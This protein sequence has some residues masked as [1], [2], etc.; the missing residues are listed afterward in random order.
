MNKLRYT[1]VMYF[2]QTHQVIGRAKMHVLSHYIDIQSL[3]LK[4]NNLPQI[5]PENGKWG[6][7]S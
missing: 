1:E 6:N 2:S 5:L 7:I 4:E 3:V